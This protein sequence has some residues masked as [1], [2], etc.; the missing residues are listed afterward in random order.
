MRKLVVIGVVSLALVGGVA[1]TANSAVRWPARCH[2]FTCVNA[3][4]NQLR[5]QF[6]A[7]KRSTNAFKSSTNYLLNCEADIPLTQYGDSAG[8]Y[9][10]EFSNDGVSTIFTTALDVTTSGDDV[11]AWFVVDT[12]NTT[13]PAPRTLPR[14][15]HLRP[16]LS[17]MRP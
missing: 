9:G 10:Y 2:T 12:C 3:H 4:M 17:G 13:N 15:L 7:F 5:S 11:D 6:I 14:G 8:T 16:H 1:G